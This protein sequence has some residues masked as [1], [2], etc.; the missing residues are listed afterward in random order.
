MYKK[1]LCPTDFSETANEAVR[2]AYVLAKAFNAE[3][4]L[5]HVIVPVL[6]PP[7]AYV[8]VTYNLAEYD[9]AWRTGAEARLKQ[10]AESLTDR[11]LTPRLIVLSG[12]PAQ[13]IEKCAADEK[14]DL[15]VI[16]THGMTGWRHYLMGSVAQK[17]IQHV[18]L[19]VLAVRGPKSP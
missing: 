13:V 14:A 5:L 16:A 17:V 3:L 6:P 15:I 12:L 1:I 9:H 10:T 18:S 19:P 7:D 8:P 2:T 11:T 4:I